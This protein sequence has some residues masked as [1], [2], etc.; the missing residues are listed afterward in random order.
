AVKGGERVELAPGE[1]YTLSLM[2][3]PVDLAV[4][5]PLNFEIYTSIASV[6]KEV[7]LEEALHYEAN[8]I[9]FHSLKVED[10]DIAFTGEVL[11][12]DTNCHLINPPTVEGRSYTFQM[13][14]TRANIFWSSTAYA[15]PANVIGPDTKWV[16]NIIWKDTDIENVIELTPSGSTG[17]GPDAMVE[18]KVDYQAEYPYGNAVI[19]VK[20]ADDDFNP[21]E[22][23]NNEGYLWSWHIWISDYAGQTHDISEGPTTQLIMDRNL[24]AR[25]NTIGDPRS[26]GLMY[27]WGRKDPF[28]GG[29]YAYWDRSSTSNVVMTT[30]P[31]GW[32]DNRTGADVGGTIPWA[33]QHPM[34]FIK[35]EDNPKYAGTHWMLANTTAGIWE[36]D[37][38]T[39][40]DPCP[41]GFKL[42]ENGSITT[43][44]GGGNSAFGALTAD[45]FPTY[46][47]GA[48]SADVLGRLMQPDV[49]FPTT[50][51]LAGSNG[52]IN[53]V[54]LY[55][56]VTSVT[57]SSSG[58]GDDQ[59]LYVRCLPIKANEVDFA[60][61]SLGYNRAFG[62]AARCIVWEADR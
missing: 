45:N 61:Y 4:G 38:K 47:A 56:Y 15:D 28:V 16:A 23:A 31:S 51:Y 58:S 52:T 33:V 5:T 43:V 30:S 57:R 9:Y 13:P 8:N 48:E 3:F 37:S 60:N 46:P 12:D 49:W 19:G 2:L 32:V 55:S 26:V 6:V 29:T 53:N 54:R 20:L 50:G 44:E 42:P 59:L 34:S 24:G 41:K 11:P 27:Q 36:A 35:A 18:F 62:N 10:E 7:E 21:I 22:P 14:I 25:S 1:S 17:I 39:I 40:Y